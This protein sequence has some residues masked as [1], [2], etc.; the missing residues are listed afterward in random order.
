M[1]Q[2]TLTEL[3]Q[4]MKDSAQPTDLDALWLSLGVVDDGF[5][6]TAPLASVRRAILS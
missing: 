1:G 2:T 3:Y 4:Q 6:D 5:D